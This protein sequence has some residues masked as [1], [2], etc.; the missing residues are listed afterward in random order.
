MSVENAAP[1]QAGRTFSLFRSL[2]KWVKT[3]TARRNDPKRARPRAVPARQGL[4]MES[5]EQRTTIS[6]AF[7]GFVLPTLVDVPGST[8]RDLPVG[9]S[10]VAVVN[11]GILTPG[12]QDLALWSGGAEE[13]S[14][15]PETASMRPGRA[16]S[17]LFSPQ[18]DWDADPLAMELSPFDTGHAPVARRF[19][20][21]APAEGAVLPAGSFLP[22]T[23]PLLAPTAPT[24]AGHAPLLMLDY[25]VVLAGMNADGPTDSDGGGV[26]SSGWEVS[27]QAGQFDANGAFMGATELMHLVGYQ[28]KLF[29]ATSAFRSLPRGDPR[30]G[31]QIM[32]LDSPDGEWVVEKH[33]DEEISK[34]QMRHERV[35]SLK[36]ITFTTDGEGQPL[37]EPVSM[38]LAS[39]TDRYGVVSV[40]VRDDVTET[41][42]EMVLAYNEERQAQIRSIGFHQDQVTGVDRVFA[43]T[44]SGIFSGVYDPT[45]AGNIR[46]DKQPEHYTESRVMSFTVANGTLSAVMKPQMYYRVDGPEPYWVLVIEYP[47]PPP[48]REGL[49]GLT[50]IPAL[51]GAG[52]AILASLEANPGYLVRIAPNFGYNY[53]IEL[54]LVA[55]LVEQWGGIGYESAAAAYNDMLPV[56]DP[57]TGDTVHLLGIMSYPPAGMRRTSSWYLIRYPDATYELHEIPAQPHPIMPN[58]V[59][60]ANR[61]I[62][63][64]PFAEDKGQYFYFGGYDTLFLPARNTAWIYRAPIE[65]VFG[66]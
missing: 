66:F 53:V 62:L 46:W 54:D 7:L 26:Q 1:T 2:A 61:T 10:T 16:V 47:L 49:R 28:G 34:T 23:S 40:F 8:R 18:V 38:L 5:L 14:F 35:E 24:A 30:V 11:A 27:W 22:G 52:E 44:N 60:F 48:I 43:G 50:T 58:P 42:T 17:R 63:V 19:A 39:P 3:L 64:S 4:S 12:S 57:R 20:Q 21:G 31:G 41:W 13:K 33:F 25:L 65:T 59:L 56:T 37:Q 36:V 51:S 9:P 45:V 32:R 15:W 55:F 29:A 6:D